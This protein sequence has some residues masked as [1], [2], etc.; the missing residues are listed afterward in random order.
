MAS[1]KPHLLPK[2]QL[3]L[4]SLPSN[5]HQQR[6]ELEKALD[7]ARRQAQKSKTFVPKPKQVKN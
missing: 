6:T 2:H 3:P 5:P 1:L 7:E 4:G